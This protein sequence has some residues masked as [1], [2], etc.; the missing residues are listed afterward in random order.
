MCLREM[1]KH[2]LKDSTRLKLNSTH[3][4]VVVLRKSYQSEKEIKLIF[5]LTFLSLDTL[6][7]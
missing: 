6:K 5:F 4:A 3:T 1:K 2:P 7:Q